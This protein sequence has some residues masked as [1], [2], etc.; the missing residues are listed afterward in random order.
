MADPWWPGVRDALNRQIFAG[1]AHLGPRLT[2]WQLNRIAGRGAAA[3]ARLNWSHIRR[4]RYNLRLATGRTPP[5]SVVIAGLASWLRTYVEVLALPRWSREQIV[6][7]VYAEPRGEA[8]LRAAYAD[9]GAVV[10]LPHSANY[11]LA[12]AW[13]CLTGMPVTTVA[14]QLGE[15]EYAAFTAIRNRL[16]MEVLPHTRPHLIGELITAA[17]AGRLV[18]L[19][20][21]RDLTGS[22][23]EAT[24]RGHRVSAPA[25][26]AMVARRAGV[27]LFAAA[28]HYGPAG[29]VIEFSDPIEALPGGRAGLQAMVQR[30]IDFI[31]AQVAAYPY[32]WHMMQPFFDGGPR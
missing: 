2:P 13:A 1:V 28:C 6:S 20:A 5:E 14:E 27:P 3:A 4:Y 25:G 29:M 16:G 32:D 24:W 19:V 8:A 26:P 31:A 9:T 11:D 10:A 22:G 21:D 30:Q 23:I 17:K 12:G 15:A 18:C 7:K